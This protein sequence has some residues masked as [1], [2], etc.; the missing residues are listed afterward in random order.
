MAVGTLTRE[1][2]S[3]TKLKKLLLQVLS[4]RRPANGWPY[5][6]TNSGATGSLNPSV[7]HHLGHRS[8]GILT[9]ITGHLLLGSLSR[10]CI[11][12]SLT[13]V[14]ADPQSAADPAI[15]GIRA[16]ASTDLAA[17]GSEAL[18]HCSVN[19]AWTPSLSRMLSPQHEPAAVFLQGLSSS[20]FLRQQRAISSA[21]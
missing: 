8:L 19:T 14:K 7:C 15:P 1:K 18:A 5:K 6:L 17:T 12:S 9:Q 20:A 10:R 2:L 3:P 11:S 16:A 21:K 13:C 4:Q